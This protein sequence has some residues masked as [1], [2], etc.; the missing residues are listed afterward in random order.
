MNTANVSVSLSGATSIAT[1]TA[2]AILM[3]GSL[4]HLCD[5]FDIAH[6]L[7]NNLWRTL[8]LITIPS[9]ASIGGA[10][11]M[12]L[13]LGGS[14]LIIYSSFAI[15]LANAMLPILEYKSIEKPKKN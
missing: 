2:Q 13:R 5:L 7:K 9:L 4:T 12:G 14:Y 15:A 3:D 1:D 10:L 6:K 8:V 11:F